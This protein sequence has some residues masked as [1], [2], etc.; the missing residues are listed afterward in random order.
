MISEKVTGQNLIEVIRSIGDL[1]G[2]GVFVYAQQAQKLEY[3]NES[4]LNIFDIS[5]REFKSQPQ[6]FLSHI[7]PDDLD[8]LRS[9]FQKLQ[10]N[11]KAENIEFKTRS[12]D[13][14]IRSQSASAYVINGD[15]VVGF[16]RDITKMREHEN[17]IINYGAKKNTLLDMVTHNLSAPLHI[18]KNLIASLEQLLDRKDATKISEHVQIIRENTSQCI[19]IVNEFLEEEHMVSE[20]IYTKANRFDLIEKIEAI[21]DRFRK[22]YKEHTFELI[23]EGET[24]FVSTDDV[25]LMQILNN[26]ISNSVKWTP[27]GRSIEI[28][29][30]ETAEDLLISVSDPGVGIPK[31][32]QPYV[33]QRNSIAS[34]PGLA[35]EKS[36][37]M[38]L[39]ISRKLTHLIQGNIWFESEENAGTTFFVQIPKVLQT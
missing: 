4:L 5:H 2:D 1:C 29:L 14:S 10:T 23:H 7:L 32:I 35:G 13:G 18:S 8:H 6:F 33:F 15:H 24:R 26:L 17:Y 21:L 20:H 37:G 19:D 22:G 28:R 3:V 9:E 34:R 16:I 31:E 12:H 11:G 39:F 25:K 36:I 27:S 38:G 30:K